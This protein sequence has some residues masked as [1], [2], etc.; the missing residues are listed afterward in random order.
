MR[1][2]FFEGAASGSP[3]SPEWHAWRAAGIGG[4]DAGAIAAAHGLA[5]RASW[6]PS[7]HRLWLQKTGQSAPAAA[8]AAMARGSQGE[9]PARRAF[10]QLT[11]I[12]VSPIF[13]EMDDHPIVRASLDGLSFSGDVLCEI[14]CP[15]E[16]VHALAKAGE[17]VGY[18]QPQLAHQAMVAWGHPEGWGDQV[19]MFYSFVPETGDGALV[20]VPAKSLAPLAERLLQ[21]ELEFW[22]YVEDRVPPAGDAFAQAAQEWLRLVTEAE[23]LEARVKEARNRVIE[24]MGGQKKVEGSGVIAYEAETK[25]RVDYAALIKHLGISP[26]VVEQFRGS[27][28]TTIV[29]KRQTSPRKGAT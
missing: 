20:E 25:G 7:L 3:N 18:Y 11:G 8:N 5:E 2:V 14:K 26:E 16:K 1:T 22:R 24:L 6:M 13:G 17:V 9:E 4:S 19:V 10:E 15:S 12:P 27:P 21:A 28:T 23:E 29:V